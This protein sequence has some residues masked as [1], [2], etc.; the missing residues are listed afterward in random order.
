MKDRVVLEHD[1]D[2]MLRV[3]EGAESAP[4]TQLA[5]PTRGE[6]AAKRQARERE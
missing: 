6:R 1:R 5:T 2:T 3:C 4:S